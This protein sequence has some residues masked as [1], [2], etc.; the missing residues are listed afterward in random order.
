MAP[1]SLCGPQPLSPDVVM[2]TDGAT[3]ASIVMGRATLRDAVDSGA[4]RVDGDSEALRRCAS[5][6]GLT[7][8]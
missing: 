1:S 7:A 6:F 5:V 3:Y 8:N 4:A 2:S